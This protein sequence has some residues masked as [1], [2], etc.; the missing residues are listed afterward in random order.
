MAAKP[1]PQGGW[2]IH[3]IKHG[4]LAGAMVVPKGIDPKPSVS[5]LRATAATYEVAAFL[6]SE[7]RAIYNWLAGAR[8]VEVS[9]PWSL[10]LGARPKTNYGIVH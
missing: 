7:A 6:P 4:H 2:E 5:A 10:P 1:T 3:L 8:L 9:S